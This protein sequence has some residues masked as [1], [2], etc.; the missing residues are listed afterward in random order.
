[1]RSIFQSSVLYILLHFSFSELITGQFLQNTYEI[2]S[3]T[4]VYTSAPGAEVEIVTAPLSRPTLIY[5][6]NVSVIMSI[7]IL[8]MA[9]RMDASNMQKCAKSRRSF[10][11]V[12]N[13]SV[14]QK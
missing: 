5:N 11:R 14:R 8:T 9:R 2:D 12:T 1:M 7:D 4:V 3:G 10:I 13:P 6:C